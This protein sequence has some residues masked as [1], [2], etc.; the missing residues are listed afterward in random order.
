MKVKDTKT[1]IQ[2]KHICNVSKYLSTNASF[3]AARNN[4]KGKIYLM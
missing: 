3:N 1:V 2:R 4:A